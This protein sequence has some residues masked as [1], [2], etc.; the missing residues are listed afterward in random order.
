MPGNNATDAGSQCTGSATTASPAQAAHHRQES[1]IP[2]PILASRGSG[3]GS[4]AD[5]SEGARRPSAGVHLLSVRIHVKQV[6]VAAMI[7]ASTDL[8]ER[9]EKVCL[10]MWIAT[11][12]GDPLG[13]AAEW[14]ARKGFSPLWNSARRVFQTIPV[15]DG[16]VPML[17]MEL[18]GINDDGSRQMLAGPVELPPHKVPM[19]PTG[20]GMHRTGSSM[21]A[22]AFSNVPPATMFLHAL[23]PP[24]QSQRKTVFLIRHGES[25]WN[26]AKRGKNVYR[27]VREHDHPLNEDG[28][29][30]A[31]AL[32]H[33]LRAAVDAKESARGSAGSA[34]VGSPSSMQQLANAGAMWASPLTRAVQTALVGLAPILRAE[35][36]TLQLKLN[37][38]E[39]KNFGGFDSI[40][41]VCG[42]ECYKR[43]LSELR[44]LDAS[45]GGPS[46]GDVSALSNLSEIGRAHV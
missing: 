31:L 43:A 41:R 6:K 28:Y 24:P 13:P 32:Q 23:P 8:V 25:K 5:A 22:K 34:E 21:T 18:W 36:A 44:S 11:S 10:L 40:G 15:P 42:A 38:R 19:R 3:D 29:R 27:M 20:I 7:A 35:G 16:S 4:D 14:P 39:K 33:A 37:V 12:S 30:Q 46:M 2:P 9:P 26:A 17:R 1:R 45:E